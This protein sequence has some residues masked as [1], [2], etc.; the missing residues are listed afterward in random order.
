[1]RYFYQEIGEQ[2]TFAIGVPLSNRRN[3][4]FKGIVGCF[5]NILP[6][7]LFR[8]N[9]NV[10]FA[11]IIKQVRNGLLKNHRRQE[12]PFVEIQSIYNKYQKGNLFHV[13]FTFEGP[14]ELSLENIDVHSK[15]IERNGAQLELFLTLWKSKTGYQGFW[16]FNTDKFENKTIHRFIDIF[17][18]IIQEVLES[19]NQGYLDYSNSTRIGQEIYR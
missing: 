6:F 16:E 13:G 4:E 3:A 9:K 15:N 12:I 19:G 10:T 18:T 1:M 14:T 17:K 2:K 7:I 8:F 11:D 5:V